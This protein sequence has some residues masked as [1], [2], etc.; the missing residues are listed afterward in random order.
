LKASK[1]VQKTTKKPRNSM[2]Y[3]AFSL[4]GVRQGVLT[5]ADHSNCIHHQSR[6]SPS[7]E[8]P[9][10]ASSP[11][12]LGVTTMRKM[13]IAA[14]AALFAANM[15][16]AADTCEAQ[17]AAK[18][19]AGA[20]K[21][22]F[23]KKCEG[24][25]AASGAAAACEAQA[26]EKKLAGAASSSFVKKCEADAKGTSAAAACETQASEKKLAGAAKSSFV[27]KCAAD[28]K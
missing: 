24:D 12:L 22:S 26:K 10:I 11:I 17:A 23:M 6:M 28:A 5:E 25:T 20:A 14:V 1:E 2:S 16:Y 8:L 4:I 9:G 13:M 7:L 15:A 18:K 3:G 21:T 27:K 19:L